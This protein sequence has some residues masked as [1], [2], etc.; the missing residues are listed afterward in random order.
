MHKTNVQYIQ[1]QWESSVG[2]KIRTRRELTHA[3]FGYDRR[4]R[5]LQLL[6]PDLNLDRKLECSQSLGMGVTINL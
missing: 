1:G 3:S 5:I 4:Y 2:R 6:S